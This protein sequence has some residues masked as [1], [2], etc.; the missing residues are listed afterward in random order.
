LTFTRTFDYELVGAIMRH[1][2]LYQ[3]DD[4]S[5]RR[6]DYNPDENPLI[7]YV[8]VEDAGEVLG[9]FILAPQN[10]I[11][12]EIHTRLLPCAWGER[13]AAAAKG[14]LEWVWANTPA[15]RLVTFC[16][17]YNRLAIRF[18]KRAGMTEY[19]RNPQSWQ[20]DG[21][22]HDQVLLGISRS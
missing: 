4:F 3:A 6:E 16:P 12:W 19:G 10:H 21:R 13:A 7:C 8:L 9:L 11:C 20:K 14:I 15:Q 2:S 1:P 22:L 17:A 18:A 5:P